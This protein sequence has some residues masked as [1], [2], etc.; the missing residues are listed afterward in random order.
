MT[1]T[2]SKIILHLVWSTKLRQPFINQEIKEPLYRYMNGVVNQK[3]CKLYMINGMPDHVHLLISVPLTISIPALI[4]Q[5]K[6]CSTRWI[7]K[8]YPYLAHFS[9]QEGMGVFSVGYAN[10]LQVKSYIANQ[11]QHHR[12]ITFEE[13]YKGFLKRVKIKF[14]ERFVLG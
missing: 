14:D 13:E 11:E 10:L 3:K 5:L 8:E 9:W 12:H 4:Q 6:V 2:Y 1:H 7:R